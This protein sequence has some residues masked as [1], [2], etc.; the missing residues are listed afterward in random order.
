MNPIPINATWPL[1]RAEGVLTDYLYM[2]IT[3]DDSAYSLDGGRKGGRE[4]ERTG[5]RGERRD[6]RRED[7]G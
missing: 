4:G 5:G 1:S 3:I 7:Q 2:I 6:V